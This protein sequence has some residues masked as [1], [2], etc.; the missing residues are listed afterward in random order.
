MIGRR[1]GR[2]T[3]AYSGCG[4]RV[5]G[6][7][8]ELDMTR[9]RIIL[10]VVTLAVFTVVAF[11]GWQG[12]RARWARRGIERVEFGTAAAAGQLPESSTAVATPSEA[13]VAA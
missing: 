8:P 4:G 11:G 6:D 7:G 2:A 1:P 10:L 3:N 9:K 12:V 13:S 5:V